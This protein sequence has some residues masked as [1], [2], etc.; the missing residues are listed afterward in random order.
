MASEILER[1]GYVMVT[2]SEITFGAFG[3]FTTYA[4]RGCRDDV[5]GPEQHSNMRHARRHAD[6]LWFC[7]G[8]LLVHILWITPF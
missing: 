2:D 5:F 6:H 7:L 8:T 1:R 4:Q 3:A